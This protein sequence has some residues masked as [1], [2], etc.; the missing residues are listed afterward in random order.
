MNIAT[1]MQI[2]LFL[3]YKSSQVVVV[4]LLLVAPIAHHAVHALLLTVIS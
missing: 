2:D 1:N 3:L 4:S